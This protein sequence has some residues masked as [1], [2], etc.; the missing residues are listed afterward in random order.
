VLTPPPTIAPFL[1]LALALAAMP[2]AGAE[3][4][5]ELDNAAAVRALA[6]EVAT[7]RRPVH[8]RGNLLLVTAPRN[9]LVLLD[10]TEGIYVELGEVVENR[11][12][13]GDELDVTGETD[14]G[15][16]APIVRARRVERLGPG[17][18]PLPRPTT[19]AELNAGGFDAAWVELR[20]IVRACVPTPKERMPVSR[21]G[22]GGIAPNPGESWLVTFA[23]GDDKM[24]VQINGQLQPQELVDA[25]V[26]L[27]GVVFNV[28]NANRQF[29][30]ANLQVA[31]R[32]MVEVIVPPPADPFA[33]PVQ[34][35]S[36]VLRFSRSGFTGRRVHVRGVVTGHKGGHTLWLRE[37]E[38]G[39]Q[40]DSAQPGDLTPGDWVD[41]VGFPDHGSYTPSLSDAV[42]R[43]ISSGPAPLAQPLR[44]PEDIA[45]FDA[46]LVQ[47]DAELRELRMTPEG[48]LL[49]LRW[50]G[51]EVNGRLSQLAG[52]SAPPAWEPGSL[53]R[54]T[55]ICLTG[56]TN[57]LR[58]TGLWVA[59]D[60]Q[61]WLRNAADISVLRPAPWLTLHR[62]LGLVIAVLVITLLALVAMAVVTRRQIAQR[63]EA[64]KLAEVE[65]S[66]MLA[67]RNRL[68]RE[69]HDTLAQDLNAVSMQ[70]ELARNAARAGGAEAV[71]GFL[72]AAHQIVRQCLASARESIWD[73]RS[74]ILERH[75]L[76]GALKT[77]AEQLRGG[78]ACE[79]RVRVQGQPRRLAPQV[80][81]NLLRV[82]QEA[83]SNALKHARPAT[84][85][86]EFV[87]D[88]A[89][90]RLA[91]S[92]SGAGFDPNQA[93]GGNSHF[94]LRG[95]RE[96]VAQMGGRL[97]VGPG[98]SGGTQVEV[99]VEAPLST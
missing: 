57:F 33:L 88:D 24:E 54:V 34:P 67:E 60:L 9:A 98:A 64:R 52:E 92:D 94:G 5:A 70:L 3:S 80:E 23:Q 48:L 31:N 76:V 45:R 8:L 65:F 55:G 12:R 85:D 59:E 1:A 26:R 43:K 15:D 16:F 75:D 11:L 99:V 47:I 66:A 25:E 7:Q 68:A 51:I 90:V 44:R 50:N 21:G 84:I 27:R 96:R 81:N 49:V 41:V 10:R 61:L 20:G 2:A 86:L 72:S 71:G 91:V 63:E 35:I 22:T 40:I 6:P 78:M 19:I 14:A 32:A 37:G 73:M 13:L 46:N 58:P 77:V 95:M 62:A 53:L 38:R 18:L 39:M 93:A 36:E 74:H 87:F 30:R 79:I 17:A 56:R 89:S 28:H 69:I 82:G 4:P 83:V 29:V 97:T 42:F